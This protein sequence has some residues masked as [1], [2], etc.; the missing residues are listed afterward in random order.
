MVVFAALA[1]SAGPGAPGG[2]APVT[3]A[4]GFFSQVQADR[5]ARAF[6]R[7]CRECHEVVDFR[8]ADFEWQWRRRTA[9]NLF[10]RMVETMPEDDPGMLTDATYVDLIAYILSLNG[11]AMGR[12]ELTATESAL[13]VIPLGPGARR[14]P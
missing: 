3:E 12:T 8:G 4:T 10:D 14:V 1:C 2:P 9:W 11:Y 5:G 13:R 6:A 7:T